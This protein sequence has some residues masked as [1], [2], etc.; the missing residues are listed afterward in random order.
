[1]RS[2]TK[3]EARPKESE[4]A[5]TTTAYDKINDPLYRVSEID[6]AKER[7][8][9]RFERKIKL[10]GEINKARAELCLMEMDDATDRYLIRELNK[11]PYSSLKAYFRNEARHQ[12]GM[13]MT[14]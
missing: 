12:P 13:T 7:I 3:V 11:A 2:P 14:N 6:C 4:M 10:V 1:M 5:N 9:S 8:A